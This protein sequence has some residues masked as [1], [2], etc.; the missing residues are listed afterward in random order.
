MS[1]AGQGGPGAGSLFPRKLTEQESR[2]D[3]FT[4][5]KWKETLIYLPV[6]QDKFPGMKFNSHPD[7]AL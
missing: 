2:E 4:P 5:S 7:P 1:W 3:H 6:Q